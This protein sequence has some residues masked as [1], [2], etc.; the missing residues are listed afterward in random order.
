L[1][2]LP[3]HGSV[4]RFDPA[5]QRGPHLQ[6][7]GAVGA[8][9]L[10]IHPEVGLALQGQSQDVDRQGFEDEAVQA[11]EFV[12]GSLSLGGGLVGQVVQ[13]IFGSSFEDGSKLFQN[14]IAIRR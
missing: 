10:A 4:D 3:G 13:E 7:A 2:F 1:R 9:G 6:R 14:R 11:F 8:V 12:E 5:S